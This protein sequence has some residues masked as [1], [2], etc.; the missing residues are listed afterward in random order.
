MGQAGEYREQSHCSDVKRS[1]TA[2]KALLELQY[3]SSVE[4]L[5]LMRLTVLPS[6]V[7]FCSYYKY[8]YKYK[9]T[10]CTKQKFSLEKYWQNHSFKLHVIDK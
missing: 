10:Y 2:H 6:I 9:C 7:L 1:L 3:T 8:E 5:F 4:N